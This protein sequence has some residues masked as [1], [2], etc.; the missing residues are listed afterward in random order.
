MNE[1]ENDL[2]EAPIETPII[3]SET[4]NYISYN[5]TECSSLI[6]ILSINE[7]NNIIEFK[8]LNKENNHGKKIMPIKNYL[9]K[10]KEYSNKYINGEKCKNHNLYYLSYCFDCNKHLC[11]KCLKDRTHINHIKNNILEIEPEEQELSIIN[12]VIYD[13]EKK[14]EKL[15]I[16]KINKIKEL[17]ESLNNNKIREQEKIKNKILK[18]NN[19]KE[20]KIKLNNIE[21]LNDIEEIKRKY[22]NEIK[23]RKILFEQKN[24]EIENKYK[25]ISEKNYINHTYKIN[26]LIKNYENDIKNLQYDKK[27]NNLN[28]LKK[29]NELIYNIYNI[30]KNNYYNSLNINNLLV[31]YSKNE[32]IRNNIMKR[33][34]GDEYENT[35]E[36]IMSKI[37]EDTNL[38]IIKKDYENK[39]FQIKEKYEKQLENKKGIIYNEMTILYEIKINQDKIRVFGRMFVNNHKNYCKIEYDGKEYDLEEYFD[40]KEYNLNKMKLN[41]NKSVLEIKLKGFLN[42]LSYMFSECSSPISL[43]DISKLNLSNITNMSGMFKD[44]SSLKFLP[45]ISE[46]D[47]KNVIDMSELFNGCSLLVELPDIS[48]WNTSNVKYMNNLFEHCEIFARRIG[49]GCF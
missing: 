34:L 28:Y 8:C 36:L 39:L 27:I 30:F 44:C 18:F 11:K 16:Q 24:S 46:L 23:Q 13:Y 29:I 6:E 22:E 7:E 5:C 38:D 42:N 48:K 41:N 2:K 32:Y 3:E 17:Q 14:I 33:I 31:S 45:D 15:Q 43:P 12:D 9:E 4:N 20:E 37:N 40:L 49:L 10:M 19:Q 21:Y 1:E 25:L 35:L 26:E 47:I